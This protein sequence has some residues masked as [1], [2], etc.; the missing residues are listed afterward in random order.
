M[1]RRIQPDSS[2]ETPRKVDEFGLE[3]ANLGWR[4]DLFVNVDQERYASD[5]DQHRDHEKTCSHE[6]HCS[7]L[8]RQVM[9]R[10]CPHG[11]CVRLSTEIARAND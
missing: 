6:L 4:R 7:N 10:G 3:I 1:P 5:H 8:E 2:L 9:A 11:K